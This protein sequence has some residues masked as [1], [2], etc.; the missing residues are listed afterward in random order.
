MKN[1]SIKIKALTLFFVLLFSFQAF[2]YDNLV[3]HPLLTTESIRLYN[4]TAES[5]LSQ[6]QSKW[7]VYGSIAE[8]TDPRYINHYYD[9]TT[10]LGLN[11]GIFKGQSAKDW[12]KNQNSV[13]GDYSE[14]AIFY[15][16]KNENYKRAYQGIGHIL[17][18]VQ[19]MSVPAHTRN[20]EHA[21]GDPFEAW[22]KD[23]GQVE[24][25]QS[26][27]ISI[28]NIDQAFDELASYSHNNFFSEDTIDLSNSD[29]KILFKE[30]SGN[31]DIE[32]GHVGDYKIVKRSLRSFKYEYSLDD[33]VH[34]DYWNMLYPKAVGYSAGVIDYFV[35]EFEKIDQ[36]KESEKISWWGKIKKGAGDSIEGV[37]YVWGDASIASRVAIG[38]GYEKTKD[39]AKSAKEKI[40]F[41]KKEEDSPP[42]QGGQSQDEDQ[43]QDKDKDKEFEE[44]LKEE[45]NFPIKPAQA[46]EDDSPKIISSPKKEEPKK[47]VKAEKKETVK[48]KRIIDGDTIEL[49]NGDRVR[50]IGVDTPELGRP[51][52]EDDEC[53]A[54]FARVRN[55]QL[56]GGGSVTLVKDPAVEK[57]KYGRLLRYVYVGGVFVNQVLVREGLAETFFC[58]PGWQNCP[59]TSDEV[60]KQIILDSL[61]EADDHKRGL[62]SGVCDEEKEKDA[63][64]LG[65]K[66]YFKEDEKEKSKESG[67]EK[68]KNNPPPLILGGPEEENEEGSQELDEQDSSQASESPAPED[69]L[70]TFI[71]SAPSIVASSSQAYFSFDSNIDSNYFEYKVNN[72]NWVECSEELILEN[73]NEGNQKIQARIKNENE[74]DQTPAEYEWI[75]DLSSPISEIVN[76]ASSY[77]NTDFAVE[78]QGSDNQSETDYLN[79]DIRYKI[80][81]NSWQTWLVRTASTSAVFIESLSLGDQICFQSR[82]HDYAGNVEDFGN[83][84]FCTQIKLS[85]K[86][87]NF[88]LFDLVSSSTEY[89]ASTTVG[90]SYEIINPEFVDSYFIS[91]S[92]S[93]PEL[94]NS[95]WQDDLGS[96]YEFNRGDGSREAFIF[97]KDEDDL[98]F[99]AAS[100]SIFINALPPQNPVITN[101]ELQPESECPWAISDIYWIN[102]DEFLLQGSKEE[103]VVKIIIDGESYNVVEGEI[104]WQVTHDFNFNPNELTASSFP[105]QNK[106]SLAMMMI[107]DPLHKEVFFQAEDKVGNLSDGEN[108]LFAI[109]ANKPEWEEVE[110]FKSVVSKNIFLNLY[111]KQPIRDSNIKEYVLEYRDSE[112]PWSKLEAEEFILGDVTHKFSLSQEGEYFLRV[113]AVDWAQNESEWSEELAF[114][115]NCYPVL[116]EV[117]A[118]GGNDGA[119]WENDFIEIYNPTQLVIDLNG[120]SIQYAPSQSDDWQVYVLNGQIEPEAY[121]LIKGS[122]YSE[123]G[124]AL[125][126]FDLEMLNLNMST[127]SSK[128]ALVKNSDPITGSLDKDVV[129]FVGYGSAD[130]FEGKT[131]ASAPGNARSLERIANWD[132]YYN[133]MN[134]GGEYELSGNGWDTDENSEDFVIRDIPEPQ[135]SQTNKELFS[136]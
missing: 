20:D 94:G 77:E 14:S 37:K 125:D 107:F 136:Y 98:I 82:A 135:S 21:A 5:S 86:I 22:A 23:H 67:P 132:Y 114:S 29:N 39:L 65:T 129:D 89:S 59:V 8:D 93:L 75:I 25:G 33:Q 62:F 16:Y 7:I 74:S 83:E 32:Y 45:N 81:E 2:A 64:V 96:S 110:I 68:E 27:F 97:I 3:V 128:V 120:W 90:I 17:H 19:D 57:D 54:W 124:E 69:D 35:R 56:L 100:A 101:I 121:Y 49:E 115:T 73:L 127:N 26:T 50:Y 92:S 18:L 44:G 48:I 12:A 126:A 71:I 134:L 109:D 80:N 103:D 78:W 40:V 61:Q 4:F 38:K 41:W 131:A 72:S 53:L 118:G 106:I 58:Q 70:D 63:E 11:D 105:R 60:R 99:Q 34:Q 51:G 102:Q 88:I 6:E 46:E 30:S 47:E 122:S 133:S 104:V 52:P 15:N 119:V 76:L 87:N 111:A 24:T 13:S 113:K 112:S 84:E 1:L 55:M 36:E 130:E 42:K 95:Y 116:S 10:G 123:Q 31:K 9:P 28:N 91:S 117:Y 108:L 43:D 85:P 79:F 66:I